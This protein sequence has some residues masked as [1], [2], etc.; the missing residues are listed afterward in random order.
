MASGVEFVVGSGFQYLPH[1]E[2]AWL[3][4]R[5][6]LGI[7]FM[8]PAEK[9]FLTSRLCIATRDLSENK[10]A[11]TYTSRNLSA[12]TSH[13]VQHVV[14]G[15]M[16]DTIVVLTEQVDRSD[17]CA[18]AVIMTNPHVFTRLVTVV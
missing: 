14:E 15:A 5:R 2:S 6:R 17:S 7:W 16:V 1:F 18:S 4:Q 10:E 9:K 13:L 3:L 11:F 8:S 12:P